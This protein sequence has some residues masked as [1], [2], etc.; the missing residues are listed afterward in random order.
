PQSSTP[1]RFLHPFSAPLPLPDWPLTSGQ[2]P[3]DIR[4]NESHSLHHS[5]RSTRQ[6]ICVNLRNLRFLLDPLARQPPVVSALLR[7]R[8]EK[9]PPRTI[10]RLAGTRQSQA[11]NL[12]AVVPDAEAPGVS[13]FQFT[14][15][16]S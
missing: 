14:F 16:L 3:D 8:R 9:V 10:C 13:R 12:A 2:K 15:L 6:S 11:R 5:T 4:P 1:A 7:R